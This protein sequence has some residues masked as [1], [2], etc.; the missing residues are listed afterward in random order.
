MIIICEPQ[1][2]GYEHSEFNA[3]FIKVIEKAFN[4]EILFIGEKEHLKT[5]KNVIGPDNQIDYKEIEVPPT[6][7]LVRKRT[8]FK[9]FKIVKNVFSGANKL[10]CNRIIFSSI[11]SQILASIKILLRI[12]K[13]IEILVIPHNMLEYILEQPPLIDSIFWIRYWLKF[14]N[15]PRLNYILLGKTVEDALVKELPEIQ[16]YIHYIDM[17][18]IFKKYETEK[19]LDLEKPKFGFLGVGHYKKGF[20]DFIKLSKDINI[21]YKNKA[22]FILVG[23][24]YNDYIQI[25]DDSISIISKGPLT[26]EDYNKYLSELNYVLYLHKPDVYLFTASAVLFDPIS[27]LKPIIAIKSPFV[28]YYF[29]LMGD[30][31][32]LCENMGEVKDVIIDLIKK[33]DTKRYKRQ[34]LNLLKGREKIGIEK[35]ADKIRCIWPD[36]AASG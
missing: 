6:E 14:F 13:N 19:F 30:I 34:Q 16:R 15:T 29:N 35:M 27:Y 26:Q 22:D 9:E 8:F 7:Q 12:Y 32:Y 24:V 33:P 23:H 20:E 28:Q 10:K 17:P 1:C 25:N 4:E 21:Q 11:T 2:I 3:A 31:G 5:V 36:N 18:T